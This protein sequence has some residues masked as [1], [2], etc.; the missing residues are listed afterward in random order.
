M[1]DGNRPSVGSQWWIG[2]DSWVLQDGNYTDF[3]VG[4]RRQFALEFGYRRGARLTVTEARQRA[5]V[6]TGQSMTYAVTGELVRAP[7]ERELNAFVLDFGLRAYDEWMVLD[8]LEPPPPGSWLQGEISLHVD[9]FTYMDVLARVP[10]MPPLIHAWRIDDI[11]VDTSPVIWIDASHPDYVGPDEGPSP[12]RDP[13]RESWRS[14]RRTRT[15]E[16]GGGYRLLCTLLDET[17]VST[18]SASGTRSRYG[19]LRGRRLR[20]PSRRR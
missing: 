8:D 20:L 19:P 4:Q 12:M 15:W 16:H 14:V 7:R 10:G 6:H 2:L 17:P 11:Q 3:V 5:C 13:D 18:M 9:H 1:E